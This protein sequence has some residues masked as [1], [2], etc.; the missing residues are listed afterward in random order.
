MECNAQNSPT[1]LFNALPLNIIPQALNPVLGH[2]TTTLP[3]PYKLPQYSG[4]LNFRQQ[5]ITTLYTVNGSSMYCNYFTPLVVPE[6]FYLKIFSLN[7]R[8]QLL[9]DTIILCTITK[10]GI[11]EQNFVTNQNGATF[12]HFDVNFL[13]GTLVALIGS[14]INFTTTFVNII[15]AT[16]FIHSNAGMLAKKPIIVPS[17]YQLNIIIIGGTDSQP[18]RVDLLGQLIPDVHVTHRGD[19]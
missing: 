10:A 15:M 3:T 19:L 11:M 17:G 4:M 14:G 18:N 8:T 2:A 1:S 16:G 7:G 9:D 13:V 5:L 6:G 12:E